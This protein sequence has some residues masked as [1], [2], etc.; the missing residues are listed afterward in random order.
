MDIKQSYEHRMITVDIAIDCSS[1]INILPYC[2]SS[3]SPRSPSGNNCSTTKD[4]WEGG[5]SE[6]GM[7]VGSIYTHGE[8]VN[9][10]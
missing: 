2:G 3:N 6:G 9:W 1:T 7:E 10:M 5:R 8:V 4:L